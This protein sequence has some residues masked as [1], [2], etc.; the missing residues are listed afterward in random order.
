MKNTSH[1]RQAPWSS[2]SK[3]KVARSRD[4]SDGCWPISRERNVLGRPKLV[5][6][7]STARAIKAQQ[8][9]GQ[10]RCTKTCVAD[11]RR[12]QASYC[13]DRNCIISTEREDL[14]TSEL[15]TQWSMRCQLSRPDIKL[16]SWILARGRG[17][18]VSAAP[19]GHAACFV[20]N[21]YKRHNDQ[22]D[23]WYQF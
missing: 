18:T 13:W 19:C 6:R 21:V 22:V 9:Q 15:V 7:L 17:H 8:F 10:R 11:K 2:R 23:Y 1:Q 14:R 16:W 3:V 4:A 5:G 20:Q 12:H